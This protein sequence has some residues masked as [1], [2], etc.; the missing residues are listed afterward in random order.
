MRS[1]LRINAYINNFPFNND[2]DHETKGCC[3]YLQA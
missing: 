2:T 1:H 3:E